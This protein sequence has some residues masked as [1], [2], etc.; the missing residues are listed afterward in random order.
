MFVALASAFSPAGALESF[1]GVASDHWLS[2]LVMA[3]NVHND[4]SGYPLDIN[5]FLSLPAFLGLLLLV[6]V[7][8]CCA[9]RQIEC[10]GRLVTL[11][12]K[13]GYRVE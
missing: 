11:L 3:T 1:W 8:C 7:G 4:F 2:L 10:G 6:V 13:D 5:Q 12:W 9:T